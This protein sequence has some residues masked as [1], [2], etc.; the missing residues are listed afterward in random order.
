MKVIFKEH[1]SIRK[2]PANLIN[3][4]VFIF[5]HEFEK[6]I[7]DTHLIKIT[8]AYIFNDV[9]IKFLH[10]RKYIAY[11]QLYSISN[12]EIFKRV[13]L[14]FRGIKT[15]PKGVWVID[16]W[17]TGYFHWL[18]DVLPRWLASTKEHKNI[19]IL[20]PQQYRH[21]NFIAE[22]LELLGIPVIYYNNL[23]GLKVKDLL[24]TSYTADTGNYNHKLINELREKFLD[25]RKVTG[26]RKVFI[27]RLKAPIRKIVNEQEVVDC[28]K[29]YDWE[30]HYFE[31]YSFEKQI[32]IMSQTKYLIGLHGAGLTNMLFMR[33][34]GKVLELRNQGDSLNNCYFS[35]ASEL[36]IDYYYQ[37]NK[38]NNNDTHIVDIAVDI[39]ILEKNIKI[40]E[41]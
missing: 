15:V 28:L 41:Q 7:R 24:I 40:M 26:E 27:S 17:S 14:L 6:K 13:L 22:S 29:L 5:A 8:N 21:I 9:I 39:D 38:G 37:L 20:L 31:D 32:E 23:A 3:D 19:P 34:G 1:T 35:L 11:S 36:N 4:D 2:Q 16:G 30:I 12:K 33:A 10:F 25:N 18:T